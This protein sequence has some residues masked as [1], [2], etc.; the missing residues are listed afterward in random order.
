MGGDLSKS[1][2]IVLV[3][4]CCSIFLSGFMLFKTAREYKL[5]ENE[6]EALDKYAVKTGSAKLS[7]VRLGPM[8]IEEEVK[9]ELARNYN[10]ADFPDLEI[11]FDGLSQVNDQVVAWLYVG[12]V[13]ISY[14]V[15]QDP[16]EGENEY[17]LHHTFEKEENSSGCI[18]MDWEVKPDLSSWNTFIYGHN[19]KN[20]TMFGSLKRLLREDGLYETDPY[21][22]VFLRNGIYRYKIF[23]YYL[24]S[25]DSK[26]YWTCDTFK[27]YRQYVR[28]ALEKSEHD[29]GVEATEDDNMLTLVT[30]S[31]TGSNKKREFVHG[32]FIDRYLYD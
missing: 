15:V 11:D 21:I 28:T 16:A 32:I 27:E 4:A 26:M 10:R 2:I 18:F 25:T 13:G 9:D 8:T 19:M 30:C 17:Y 31:G 3:I 20:G 1:Q 5:A 6:Y 23:S 29:C 24:D 7:N 22:Y 12:S 14:P